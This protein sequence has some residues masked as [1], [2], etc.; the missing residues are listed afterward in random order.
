[1]PKTYYQKAKNRKSIEIGSTRNRAKDWR[2]NWLKYRKQRDA[3]HD[4]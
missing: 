1:M 2:K 3:Q 4:S